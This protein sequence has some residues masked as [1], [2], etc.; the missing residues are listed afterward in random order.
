MKK[1]RSVS[2]YMKDGPLKLLLNKKNSI[3]KRVLRSIQRKTWY[4][5]MGP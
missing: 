1:G 2:L 3:E 5:I 4:S